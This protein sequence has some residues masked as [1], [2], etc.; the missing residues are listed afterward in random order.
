MTDAERLDWL[1]TQ[2]GC[3]LVSDDAGN[4]AVVCSGFQNV[5][6]DPPDDIQ[7]SFFIRKD[8]WQPTVREAI[9]AARR[10]D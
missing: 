4:W 10:L 5:P 7:T 8:E 2:D 6:L 3:A 1:S 9:D